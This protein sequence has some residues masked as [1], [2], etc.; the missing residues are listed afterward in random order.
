[1]KIR[2]EGVRRSSMRAGRYDRAK[3]RLSP[4][5]ERALKTTQNRTKINCLP[6]FETGKEEIVPHRAFNDEALVQLW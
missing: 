2:T 3:S 4:L 1:M 5:C 6:C